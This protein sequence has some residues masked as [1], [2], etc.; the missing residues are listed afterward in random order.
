LIS[1]P[2]N[3]VRDTSKILLAPAEYVLA[4]AKPE[5]V[6]AAADWRWNESGKQG[7]SV[8][9]GAPRERLAS[10]GG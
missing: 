2:K 1:E 6:S 4:T 10:T 5:P 3:R 9:D 8:A 7:E